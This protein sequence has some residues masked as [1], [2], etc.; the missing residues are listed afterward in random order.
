MTRC[1]SGFGSGDLDA[2]NEL[3]Q[4]F[5]L[6]PD[7]HCVAGRDG[8]LKRVNPAWERTLGYT[9][10]ELLSRPYL[11]FVHPGD[12]EATRVRCRT[13]SRAPKTHQL[14]IRAASSR[15]TADTGGT[16]PTSSVSRSGSIRARNVVRRHTINVIGWSRPAFTR[17]P[18]TCRYPRLSERGRAAPSHHWRARI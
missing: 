8:Y 16:R 4:L 7:L 10:S 6:S 12:L 17:R 14:I 11:E 18:G 9:E 15:R 3:A 5:A 13:R 2:D 1:S